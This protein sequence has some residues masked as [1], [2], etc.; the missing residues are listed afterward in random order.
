MASTAAERG[1]CA[2][3]VPWLIAALGAQS[4]AQVKESPPVELDL[5]SR[6][7]AEHV[8]AEW[9]Y[10]DAEV[11]AIDFRSPGRD[12]KPSGA[13]NH[14]YDITPHAGGA[15]FDDAD[16]EVIAPD[17]LEARR[18]TG[19][20]CFGARDPV[21]LR[22]AGAH[23]WRG[24]RGPHARVRGRA[25]RLRRGLGRRSLAAPPRPEWAAHSSLV[26]TPP[27]AWC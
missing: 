6:A 23:R 26:G 1:L 25:R 8:H 17:S 15:D 7:G 4:Q 2:L 24:D 27:T 16:W 20:I 21:V 10:R 13:P 14:T 12:R 19:R 22:G 18:G 11:R 9:R 3:V 5:G